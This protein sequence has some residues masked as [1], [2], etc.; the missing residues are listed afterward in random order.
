MHAEPRTVRSYDGSLIAC[1]DT[2]GQG[3]PV[4]LLPGW[5]C[6]QGVWTGTVEPLAA[7]GLRVVTL[8]FAG[9]GLSTA[10]RRVW[11]IENFARDV[12]AVLEGLA[13]PAATLVGHSMGGAVALEAAYLCPGRVAGVV[14]CDSF[15][16]AAFYDR[17]DERQVDDLMAPLRADYASSVRE[18]IGAYLLPDGDP[19]VAVA[20]K[21]MMGR[22]DP[23]TA[24]PAMEDFLRWDIGPSLARCPV[25]VGTVNARHFLEPAAEARFRTVMTIRTLDGVGHFPMLEK[26]AAL[27]AAIAALTLRAAAER[28]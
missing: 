27:A 2:G 25:P 21:D 18:L 1:R 8:D 13:L 7:H 14:G 28:G 19:A 4:V 3:P 20:V 12:R 6:D 22:A 17:V 23:E 15:T 26:P 9:F 10:A 24:V 5:A 11:A 16:Y